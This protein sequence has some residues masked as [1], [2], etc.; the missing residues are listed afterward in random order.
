FDVPGL[1]GDLPQT[2][3]RTRRSWAY[4]AWFLPVDGAD[5]L[6]VGHGPLSAHG[7][8][9]LAPAGGRAPRNPGRP[10]RRRRYADR[11][12][13]AGRARLLGNRPPLWISAVARASEAPAAPRAGAPRAP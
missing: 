9:R 7:N 6:R 5:D 2:G 12:F 4:D 13:A 3:Q 10:V 8:W 1:R 11:P